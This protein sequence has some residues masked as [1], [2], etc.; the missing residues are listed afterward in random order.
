MIERLE[1]LRELNDDFS[2][3]SIRWHNMRINGW[4]P[5]ELDWDKLNDEELLLAFEQI[6][7]RHFI[8]M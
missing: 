7:R 1:R 3:K 4:E 5:R 6:I 2:P 8:P